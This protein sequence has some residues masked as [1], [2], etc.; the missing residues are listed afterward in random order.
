MNNQRNIVIAVNTFAADNDEFYPDSIA[1]IG[2]PNGF[3][4]WHEPM[5]LMGHR[6]RS[7]GGQRSVSAFLRPYLREAESVYCAGAPRRSDFFDDAWGAGDAWDHPDTPMVDDP[8]TGTYCFY[9]N[10]VG[11]VEGRQS[12]FR[13]PEGPTGRRGRSQL[14]V[15]CFFGYDQWLSRGKYAS[16]E[17]FRKAE[18]VQGNE[19]WPS[20]WSA[21]LGTGYSRPLVKLWA[22]YTDGHV[23]SYSPSRA[24]VMC[25]IKNPQ[26]GEIYPSYLGPG[27]FFLPEKA[28]K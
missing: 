3:W 16:S 27:I 8:L 25:V 14:L 23:E 19:H 15:S 2:D 11:F 1:K 20:Y 6:Y 10:Y 13:G 5:K 18:L 26:T 22:G 9:W 4:N 7:P 12:F 24:E 28:L 17:A 21:R